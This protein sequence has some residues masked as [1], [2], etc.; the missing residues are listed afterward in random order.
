MFAL[1][2]IMALGSTQAEVRSK[3]VGGAARVVANEQSEQ[4]VTAR[5]RSIRVDR[6]DRFGGKKR[7][8]DKRRWDFEMLPSY[9]QRQYEPTRRCEDCRTGSGRP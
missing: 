6:I 4:S 5:R 3:S 9:I 1:V 8:E 2:E 7:I